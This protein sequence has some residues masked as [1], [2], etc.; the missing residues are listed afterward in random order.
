MTIT[1]HKEKKTLTCH[2]NMERSKKQIHTK[3]ADGKE[4]N[5]CTFMKGTEMKSVGMAGKINPGNSKRA[6]TIWPSRKKTTE[7]TDRQGSTQVWCEARMGSKTR[8][9]ETHKTE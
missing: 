8:C 3:E 9:L 6:V 7:V 1:K 2:I 4:R 5:E